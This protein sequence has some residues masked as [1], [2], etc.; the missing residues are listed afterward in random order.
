MMYAWPVGEVDRVDLNNRIDAN[1]HQNEEGVCPLH[2]CVVV[3]SFVNDIWQ[4]VHKSG[5]RQ[6]RPGAT[7]VKRK[8]K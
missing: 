8:G 4:W 6:P 7:A 1:E 5:C 3:S 2:G